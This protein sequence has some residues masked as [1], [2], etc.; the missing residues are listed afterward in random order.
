M[1]V[2]T[3][4]VSLPTG[5]VSTPSTT[6]G[7]VSTPSTTTGP[8]RL[9]YEEFIDTKIA[10]V[11]E[12]GSDPFP[13]LD[14]LWDIFA[15][16]GIRTVFVSIGTSDSPLADLEI[17]ES[18][19]CPLHVVPLDDAQRAK[20][21]E[22]KNVLTE[23]KRGENSSAF[24][25]HVDSKWI[26]P[27]NLRALD[28]LPWWEKGTV[29]ISGRVVPTEK[30]DT[31][32]TSICAGMKLKDAAKRIDLLK[33]D[34]CSFAPGLEVPLL[35]CLLADGYRPSI[36]VVKWSAMP[37]VDLRTTITAGHLQNCGYALFS[38]LENKFLYYYTD[39]NIYETC[40]WE[41]RTDINPIVDAVMKA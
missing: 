10:K 41:K 36:L 11:G 32:V 18:I 14:K 28:S 7:A 29:D 5:A 2:S 15:G 34:T 31:M 22:V 37:D 12:K 39:E 20:W 27:K 9:N 35:N 8:K 30:F 4:S 1:S 38:S 33:V 17:S 13:I 16:K 6:T 24:T 25:E 3:V 21:S 23:R 19:G 40:S 26:L